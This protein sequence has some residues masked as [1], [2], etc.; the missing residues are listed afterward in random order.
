MHTLIAEAEGPLWVN[1]TGSP[2]LASGGAGDVLTGI[3]GAFL[4]QGLPGKEA[5]AVG[6]FLHGR[7]AELASKRFAGAVPASVVAKML[8]KAEKELRELPS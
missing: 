4:A 2:G 6:A 7:A 1:P 8:P 5:A 3:I